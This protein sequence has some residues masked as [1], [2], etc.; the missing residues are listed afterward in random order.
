MV[1]GL[2]AEPLPPPA[3]QRILLLTWLR[4]QAGDDR[5]AGIDISDTD[6]MTAVVGAAD[7]DG[8]EKLVRWVASE[9]EIELTSHGTKASLTPKGWEADGREEVST[10]KVR[11]GEKISKGYCPHC[12]GDRR[13][14]VVASHEERWDDEE[15]PIWSIDTYEILKCRGC[16]TV[17]V[18]HAHLF[19]EDE[20]YE[21]NP[22]TGEWEPTLRVTLTYW[23][24]PARR[25]R[26]DWLDR[27]E[28]KGLRAL[29]DEV[30][31][32]L[33][34]DQRTLAAFGARTAIDR[35][36]VLAGG[37]PAAGFAENLETLERL[38]RIIAYEKEILSV[39][40][41]AG[42]AAAHRGWCPDPDQLS[43][44]MDGTES[45]L[46]RTLILG[47]AVE[48]MKKQVPARPTRKKK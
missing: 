27:I 44:I 36:M 15:A 7:T 33:D 45:F 26:P 6:A 38:G 34:S 35:A 4:E 25:E 28:D 12:G 10:A 23:P 3:E 46:H 32:A 2:I 16:E 43:T 42:S 48:K 24:A 41:D 37:D 18:R 14:D 9:G 8:F 30:Y 22:A 47:V 17:Y 29:L 20:V 39:L 13:A 19:S 1:D 5:F 11:A 40:T 31:V 21:R